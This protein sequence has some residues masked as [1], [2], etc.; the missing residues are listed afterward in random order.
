MPIPRVA[1]CTDTFDET[2]GVATISRQFAAFAHRERL[3]FLLVRPGPACRSYS[4][5][6]LTIVEVARSRFCIPL[7]MG[8][9]FDLRIAR[10]FAWLRDE[11]T[12]FAPDVV[13]I[14]SPG[15]I[16]MVCA[17][18]A[19]VIRVPGV[20]LVAGWHTNVH[21]Y[22]RLRAEPLLR[23]FAARAA[24]SLGARIE[25]GA[26]VAA[27]RFYRT[28]QHILAPNEEILSQLT[29]RT[30]KSGSVMPHGVDTDLFVPAVAVPAAHSR[31]G[32]L[33]LGYVGRLNPEKNVRFLVQ[34]AK[35]L[36]PGIRS[37]IR[38][39][40]VGDGSERPWLERHLPQAHFTGIL[41]DRDLAKAYAEMDIF[42]FPSQSDTFG[43]VVLEA[44]SAGVP[45]VAFQLCGPRSAVDDGITGYTAATPGEFIERVADL[46]C[47][48]SLRD[49]LGKASRRTALRFRWDT[50]F[51]S[52][53]S[54]YAAIL[55]ANA[56]AAG[57]I[58]KP[59]LQI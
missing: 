28:A 7:D 27:A 39:L 15:D 12:A 30:G 21:Q 19:H 25:A 50:V 31:D 11:F 13:H 53:Y 24:A 14:T 18:L 3:K 51:N 55:S 56:P 45:V 22:A 2:N 20:P 6:S 48:F 17:R 47:D 49:R 29:A 44:M 38:F 46:V 41:R 36:P 54:A 57:E 34:I 43:L 52:F 40:I 1:F 59:V 5:N 58:S 10:H 8:L 37:Q 33:T 35:R 32:L 4:E 26:F 9:R 42:L 16:G 23:L